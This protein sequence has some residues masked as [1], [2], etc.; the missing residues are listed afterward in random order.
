MFPPFKTNLYIL[1]IYLFTY[2]II[3]IID[4]HINNLYTTKIY[5]M[6]ETSIV[7]GTKGFKFLYVSQVIKSGF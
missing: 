6:V 7:W 3:N 2:N 1:K 5:Q 4:S